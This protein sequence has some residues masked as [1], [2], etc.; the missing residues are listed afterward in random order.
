MEKDLAIEEMQTLNAEISAMEAQ[1][2]VL[3]DT[4]GQMESKV[5]SLYQ[6]IPSFLGK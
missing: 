2:K 5:T 3:V 1:I 6:W 4:L